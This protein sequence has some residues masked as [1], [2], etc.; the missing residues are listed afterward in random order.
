MNRRGT[1]FR[2]VAIDWASTAIA[3]MIRREIAQATGFTAL[4]APRSTP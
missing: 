2:I 1:P 4:R 3:R